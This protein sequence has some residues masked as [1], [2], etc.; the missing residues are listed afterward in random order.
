[1]ATMNATPRHI[2][3]AGRRAD[4]Y[5]MALGYEAAEPWHYVGSTF[6]VPGRGHI[7][8]KPRARW[9]AALRR[10]LINISGH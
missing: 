1:M 5:G 7:P 9:V 6:A 10:L 4:V 3:A 8:A 2:H